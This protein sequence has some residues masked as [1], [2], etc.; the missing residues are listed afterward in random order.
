MEGRADGI[1]EEKERTAIDEIKGVYIGF[2]FPG[3]A[4]FGTQGT[5]YVLCLFLCESQ[6][7]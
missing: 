1:I 3:R 4:C 2:I 7:C 6:T 5:G